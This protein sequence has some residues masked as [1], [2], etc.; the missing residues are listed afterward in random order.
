MTAKT[1]GSI[2]REIPFFNDFTDKELKLLEPHMSIKFFRE[3]TVLR[4]QAAMDLHFHLVRSG[5]VAIIRRYGTPTEV[6]IATLKENDFFGE[7][8]FLSDSKRGATVMAAKDTSTASVSLGILID[9]EKTQP[10]IALKFYKQF[11]LKTI[12]RVRAMNDVIEKHE[13]QGK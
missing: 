4:E 6:R 8:A 2:L 9:Y 10:A 1:S 5:E 13:T 7:M 3:G 12:S 11:L